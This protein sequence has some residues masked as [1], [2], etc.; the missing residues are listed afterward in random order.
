MIRCRSGLG[1][2]KRMF[3]FRQDLSNRGQRQLFDDL[4]Q[5]LGRVPTFTKSASYLM[6]EGGFSRIRDFILRHSSAIVQ[7]PSGMPYRFRPLRLAALALWQL[8]RHAE[9][10]HRLSAA[11]SGACLLLRASITVKPLTSASATSSMPHDVLPH[12]GSSALS[13]PKAN[14]WLT[15]RSPRLV[16][17]P[18]FPPPLLFMAKVCQIT[19]VGVTRGHHIHRSGKAKKEGGIGRHITKRVKRSSCQT[20]VKKRIWVPELA[21][22]ST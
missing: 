13:G 15:P 16:S 12:G 14:F 18:F 1:S 5:R 2:S 17:R 19:G 20:F 7:D 8:P 4:S 3:Y 6:H 9:R 10:L 21:S 11:G 22:S